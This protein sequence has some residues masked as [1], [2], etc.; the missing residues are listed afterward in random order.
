M[1]RLSSSKRAALY[2]AE[3]AKA[4]AAGFGNLPLCNICGLPIDGT[5]DSGIKIPFGGGRP[6][7]RRT[8]KEL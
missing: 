2:D 6:I 7:D 1:A 8:G 5:R 4:R 3:V